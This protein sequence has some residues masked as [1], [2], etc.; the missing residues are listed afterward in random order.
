MSGQAQGV[1]GAPL[2]GYRRRK[3]VLD[4]N[5]APSEGRDDEGTSTQ[6][7][8]APVPAPSPAA[9]E[10]QASHQAPPTTIDVEA[11]DDDVIVSS[12]R[13]FAEVCFTLTFPLIL[14]LKVSSF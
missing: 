8:P 9:Q 6:P 1:R 12:P 13:A 11:L 4:L 7:A 3:A 2:R 10:G 5:V 14:V